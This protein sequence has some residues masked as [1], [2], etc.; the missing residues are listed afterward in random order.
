MIFA[1]QKRIKNIESRIKRLE[2]GKDKLSTLSSRFLILNNRDISILIG[3]MLDH[4]DAGLYGFLAPILAPLFF[5]D[6]DYVVQLILAY[7][8]LA[9][10]LITRPIGAIVFSIIARRQGPLSALSLSLMGA[11]ISTALMG[12]IPTYETI[13]WTAHPSP[14]KA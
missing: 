4:F 2:S 9:T 6:H 1:T 13:G 5:P 12:G 8:I 11:A 3:N 10:T 14:P 7:S